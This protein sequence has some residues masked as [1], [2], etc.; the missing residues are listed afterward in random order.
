MVASHPVGMGAGFT[1]P[2]KG[3]VSRPL[4]WEHRASGTQSLTT[5]GKRTELKRRKQGL[6]L[7]ACCS[8]TLNSS[9]SVSLPLF[10]PLHRPFLLL[11]GSALSLVPHSQH[12]TPDQDSLALAPQCPGHCHVLFLRCLQACF[13]DGLHPQ[14]RGPHP[15]AEQWSGLP[16]MH[17]Q[18]L[19]LASFVGPYSSPPGPES[20]IF[21]LYPWLDHFPPWPVAI[22]PHSS[23]LSTSVTAHKLPGCSHLGP[24]FCVPWA[25]WCSRWNLLSL[26]YHHS[27]KQALGILCACWL[28]D[29]VKAKQINLCFN[30]L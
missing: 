3:T 4:Q 15:S 19:A 29:G 14:H 30:F 10:L 17:C 7:G 2:S 21:I 11:T 25:M 27:T 13:L 23:G 22:Q 12:L 24:V 18:R 26:G 20:P 9:C 6:W 5:E 16:P 8:R 1:G 28:G